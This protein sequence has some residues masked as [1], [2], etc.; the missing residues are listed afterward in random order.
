MNNTADTK[1]ERIA[2]MLAGGVPISD[3]AVDCGVSVAYVYQ[4]KHKM[5][6]ASANSETDKRKAEFIEDY[7]KTFVNKIIEMWAQGRSAIEIN[8][9]VDLP[10]YTIE[11]IITDLKL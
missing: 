5:K 7:G 10:V 11:T 2:K 9:L 8:L 6:K 4:L 1:A 3:I